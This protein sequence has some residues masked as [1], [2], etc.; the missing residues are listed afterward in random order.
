MPRWRAL[1]EELDPQI[2]EFTSQLRRLVD[3]S[4]LSVATIA[5]RTGYSKSSWERYL[6]GRLLPP[7]GATQAL[8]RGDGHGRAPPRHHVGAGRTGV[9]PQPRCGTTS[10]WRPSGSPRRGPRWGS[11]GD[12]PAKGR[13]R[14]R[15]KDK[16]E[17]AA[18]RAWRRAARRPARPTRRT[19]AEVTRVPRSSRLR[20]LS[21]RRSSL[22]PGTAA[23]PRPAARARTARGPWTT[24]RRC[25]V[26][27]RSRQGAR[28][29]S[30]GTP[31]SSVDVAVAGARRP[32]AVRRPRRRHSAVR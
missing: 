27:G 8:G 1:P 7:R 16:G 3:R 21:L 6:G 24:R 13:K 2:R 15:N 11:S 17:G 25:C 30:S 20:D 12:E 26:H 19:G 18:T 31:S 10:R 23:A 28:T 22:Q 32:R 29:R 14:G 9:E 4:G 5:D